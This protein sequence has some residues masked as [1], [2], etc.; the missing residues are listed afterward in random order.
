[1]GPAVLGVTQLTF[2][3]LKAGPYGIVVFQDLN[4]N[5]ILDRNMLGAPNEPFG[6]S[7]NPTIRFSAPKFDE[8]KIDFDGNDTAINVTLNGG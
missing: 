7:N 1:M 6:F 8:F 4:G 2:T 5:E 3:D